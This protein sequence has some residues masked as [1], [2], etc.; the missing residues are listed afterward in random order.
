MSGLVDEALF[1]DAVEALGRENQ[2]DQAIEEM[3][4]LIAA[5]RHH[6]RGKCDRAAV[7]TE[8]AD[9]QIMMGQLAV[10][11]GQRAVTRERAAKLGRL[12]AML[13]EG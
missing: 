13:S 3:A 7:V 8:I 2:I 10:I 5:L 9:V 1:R 4:E 11:F 6:A 12:A